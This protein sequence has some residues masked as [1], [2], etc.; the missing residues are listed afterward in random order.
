METITIK[1]QDFDSTF[2]RIRKLLAI[3]KY[4][5]ARKGGLPQETT[6]I[7]EKMHSNFIRIINN[8]QDYLRVK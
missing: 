6:N 5:P 2:D 7:I 8:A 1:K 3:E 4:K